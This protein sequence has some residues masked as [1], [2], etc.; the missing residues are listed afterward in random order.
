[1]LNHQ[2]LWFMPY[3]QGGWEDDF[4]QLLKDL[5]YFEDFSPTFFWAKALVREGA[6]NCR[7]LQLTGNGFYL[8]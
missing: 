1:M 4:S 6:L 5:I 8:F 7:Q 3:G 2:L